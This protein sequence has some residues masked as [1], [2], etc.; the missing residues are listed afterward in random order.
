MYYKVSNTCY[1][2]CNKL[3]RCN[4]KNFLVREQ[5]ISSKKAKN[6]TYGSECRYLQDSRIGV[7]A[8]KNL[9]NR[10]AA[11]QMK[12]GGILKVY[13]FAAVG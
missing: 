5:K 13:L 12:V 9:R 3:F 6:I 10:L 11:A 2:V 4:I 1:K 7:R 8:K